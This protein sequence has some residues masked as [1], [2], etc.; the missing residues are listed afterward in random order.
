MA[1]RVG[2][3]IRPEDKGD[4]AVF[5]CSGPLTLDHTETLKTEVRKWIAGRKRIALDMRE[6][7]RMDSSGIGAVIGLYISAKR[8]NC[9]LILINYGDSI[10]ELLGVTQLLGVFEAVGR[11]GGR[12]P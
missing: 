12:L 6:V 5:Y 3:S 4:L 8:Q 10:R 1:A 7:E 9:E 2:F 11:T